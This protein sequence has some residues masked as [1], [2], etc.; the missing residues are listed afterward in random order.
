MVLIADSGS[1]KCDW[2]LCSD[3]DTKPVRIKTKGLN[4][5]ILTKKQFQKIISKS[6]ELNKI[7]HA[8]TDVKF[9]G[10]GCGT[11]RNQKKV[12]AI[13]SDFFPNAIAYSNEDTMAAIMATTTE[14]A[15]VCILGTGSNC[16]YFDGKNI[17]MKAPSMGYLLMDEASGNYFGKAL[18]RAYYYE[19]M[20]SD[21]RQAFSVDYK[22]KEKDVIKGLYKS[23]RPNKYLAAFA[24]FLFK[25][26]N[27]PFIQNILKKGMDA[28][29]ENHV[30]RYRETL[31]QVPIH[32][33][34]SI[35][36]YAQDYIKEGLRGRG[37]EV[38][39]IVKSPIE[40]IIE[41]HAKAS[42]L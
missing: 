37:I 26:E 2:I 14:P 5:A 38:G 9:F 19:T 12:N 33:V 13:L 11:K 1:T 29:V 22:L 8:V 6:T 42:T 41:K 7:K 30:L 32:F 20:P 25:H 23:A 4:P 39:M 28:F 15:V 27:H 10:A 3:D 17:H 16:C 31:K 35:A 36:F 24:P 21:L 34:G 40:N 18:L